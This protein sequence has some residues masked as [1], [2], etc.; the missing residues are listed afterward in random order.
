MLIPVIGLGK[1]LVDAIVEVEVVREDHMSTDIEQK[2]YRPEISENSQE[3]RKSHT[4]VLCA[5]SG[6]TSV[7]ARPPASEKASTISY[8]E[9]LSWSKRF[10]EPRPLYGTKV[11]DVS[12]S[13]QK[14]IREWSARRQSSHIDTFDAMAL[15]RVN[16]VNTNR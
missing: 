3:T 4:E 2:A 9:C 14:T 8:E 5:P 13:I 16:K 6:V 10:A 12:I 11:A 7:L 1:C 15:L